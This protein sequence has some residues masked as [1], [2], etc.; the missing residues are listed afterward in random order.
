MIIALT[1]PKSAGKDYFANFAIRSNPQQ[2]ISKIAFADPIKNDII[3]I[4]GLISELEYDE[5]KRADITFDINGYTNHIDGRKIVRGYGMMKRS[6]DP[7]QFVSYVRAETQKF[8]QAVWIITDLRFQNEL[9]WLREA[10]A[11]IIKIKRD[12]VYYDGHVS[13]IDLVPDSECD[14]AITND[15]SI[16]DYERSIKLVWKT[17]TKK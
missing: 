4:F 3:T 14:F 9:D 5:F 2:M 7:D 15:G 16:A 10:K 11:T 17:L 12:G 6:F 13:E 8:P 1:G